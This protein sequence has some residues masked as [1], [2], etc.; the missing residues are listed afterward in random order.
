MKVVSRSS[1]ADRSALVSAT[2][3]AFSSIPIDRP[4]PA[5]VELDRAMRLPEVLHLTGWSRSGWYALLNPHSSSYDEN[6]PRPF[7]LGNSAR[8]PSAWWLS[9]IVAYLK[10]RSSVSRTHGGNGHVA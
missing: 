7:K 10:A 8:S 2:A 9:E 4:S 6:A 3:D 1:V 5:W